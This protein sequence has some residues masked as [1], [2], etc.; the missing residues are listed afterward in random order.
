[1]GAVTLLAARLGSSV[2]TRG[3]RMS[4]DAGVSCP[5]CGHLVPASTVWAI[6]GVCSKCLQPLEAG[7][8][9][10][11]RANEAAV[12]R[13]F[14]AF[15]AR[16]LDGML[17]EMHL[18]VDFHPLRLHGL[19]SS[20]H[21]HDGVRTWFAEIERLH[22]TH[23]IELSDVRDGRDGKL[24]AVGTLSVGDPSGPASFWA[25]ERFADGLIAGAHHYLTDPQIA[26]EGWLEP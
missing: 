23:R 25:L 14:D 6:N 2:K 9:G 22:H 18:R 17:S 5:N 24:V 7:G 15:N 20:Y 3:R 8:D 10:G 21:G 26:K 1:M 4:Q 13:W 19:D 16:N 11:D 12:R